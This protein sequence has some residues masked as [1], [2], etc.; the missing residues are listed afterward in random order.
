MNHPDLLTFLLSGL[1]L[2]GVALVLG[3]MLQVMWWL[4][5]PILWGFLILGAVYFLTW[6]TGPL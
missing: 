6:A 1:F 4:R 3:C 5:W 2:A